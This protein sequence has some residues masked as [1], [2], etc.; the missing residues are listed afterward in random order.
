MISIHNCETVPSPSELS[1]LL[2][3][4]ESIDECHW[5][6]YVNSKDVP[7]FYAS[8]RSLLELNGS[9]N[10]WY[11]IARSPE[12]HFARLLKQ[13][14]NLSEDEQDIISYLERSKEEPRL[15][16]SLTQS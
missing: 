10:H 1:E 6:V 16:A 3:G 15:C 14:R 11:M 7:G 4:I 13:K 9:T 8:A 2:R 5:G 12:R